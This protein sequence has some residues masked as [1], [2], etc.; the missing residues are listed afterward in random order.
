MTSRF[1]KFA[2]ALALM[3]LV[4]CGGGDSATPAFGSGAGTPKSSATA[5]STISVLTN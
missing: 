2:C 5:V 4:S 1:A 3:A